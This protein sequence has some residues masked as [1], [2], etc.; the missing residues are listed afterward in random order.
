[1]NFRNQDL[2]EHQKLFRLPSFINTAIT[3]YFT[4]TSLQ[5]TM[6]KTQIDLGPYKAQIIIWFQDENKTA[7]EIVNLLRSSYDKIVALQT[8]QRRLKDWGITKRTRVENTA[9]LRARIAYMFCILGFTDN[10]MLHALKHEG[11]RLEKTSLVRI[12]REQ[13][14]W[15]RLSIFDR[16]AIEE[17]LR[18][19]IKDEL[20]KGSIEGYRRGLLYTHF[21]TIGFIATRF[22]L[23]YFE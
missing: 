4:R 12:R 2:Y 13:R 17:Q 5:F 22:E 6:V 15:R 18:E 23:P 9:V 8:I 20:D 1:M 14:L 7:D 3:I 10:E 11:Y 16:A 21:R 19:A